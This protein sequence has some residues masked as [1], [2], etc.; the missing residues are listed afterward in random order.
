MREVPSAAK[1]CANFIKMISI[2]KIF[3]KM[4]ICWHNIIPINKIE[5]ISQ[6]TLCKFNK[7]VYL[8]HRRYLLTTI[9]FLKIFICFILFYLFTLN[10][11]EF[12]FSI[13]HIKSKFNQYFNNFDIG[14]SECKIL[15]LDLLQAPK[16][17]RYISFKSRIGSL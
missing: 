7:I 13:G 5:N 2:L 10:M 16:N 12:L 6:I 3:P 9:S 11:L 14:H 15:C 4:L 17:S 1:L 8:H